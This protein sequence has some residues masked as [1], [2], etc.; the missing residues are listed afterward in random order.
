MKQG[1]IAVKVVSRG[2]DRLHNLPMVVLAQ[3]TDFTPTPRIVLTGT[4]NFFLSDGKQLKYAVVNG[5]L[6]D[7]SRSPQENFYKNWIN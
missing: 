5:Y 4:S 7:L 6:I 3:S 2:P 1:Y